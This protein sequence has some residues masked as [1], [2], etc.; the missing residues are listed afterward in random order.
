[1]DRTLDDP[2]NDAVDDAVDGWPPGPGDPERYR[3]S[4]Y[5][6]V[7]R[8]VPYPLFSNFDSPSREVCSKRRLVSN[9]PLQALAI[10]NDPA[11]QE[12]AT[13]LARRMERQSP[14]D[15]D[16]ALA[17]GFRASTSR[18]ISSDRL[19]V[20]RGLYQRLTK[21]YASEP[22]ILKGMEETPEQAAMVIVAS[23]ILNL[24]ESLTR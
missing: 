4:I 11:F 19:D 5:T 23:V 12:A 6:Y 18:T 8:S 2:R 9:T 10:L 16:G 24:D 21:E 13:A 22:S 1:V 3:R 17:F 14:G 7:K 15:L 20:L